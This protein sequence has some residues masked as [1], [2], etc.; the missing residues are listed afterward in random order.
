MAIV[1]R[2]DL[3]PHEAAGIKMIEPN[4][5]HTLLGRRRESDQRLPIDIVTDDP[6]PYQVRGFAQRY[7]S[8]RAALLAARRLHPDNQ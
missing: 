5:S 3:E 6:E 7:R 8:F 4:R 2:R 1:R